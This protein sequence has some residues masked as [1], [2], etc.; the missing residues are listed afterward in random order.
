MLTDYLLAAALALAASALACRAMIAVGILDGPTSERKKENAPT[1]AS[2]GIAIGLG[3]AL[4]L[5]LLV[6]PPVRDWS[7]GLAPS[8]ALSALAVI[9]LSFAFLAV[10]AVDDVRAIESRVKFALFALA[11]LTGPVLG[12]RADVMPLGAGL[13]LHLPYIVAVLGSALWVFTLVN[14]VNFMDG[15][16]GLAMGSVGAGLFFLGLL[17]LVEEQPGTAALAFCGAAALA[18]FLFWNMPSGRLFAGDSGAL[19]AGALAAFTSLLYLAESGASPLLPTILFFPLLA[20]VLLTL[21]YRLGRGAR[22]LDGHRNHFYQVGRRAGMSHAAVSLRYWLLTALCGVIALA[23]A[24]L[25]RGDLSLLVRFGPFDAEARA[26][27][28]YAP[29]IAFLALILASLNVQARVRAFA[30][31]RGLE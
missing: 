9:G 1:P 18:G 12:L 29:T 26:I 11:S 2:G 20:D 7:A 14:A 23:A 22:L 21:A 17:A 27:A 3:F 13:A 30:R 28:S 6:F 10:G 4:G 25:A 19:F 8:T 15:A 24:L 31:R 16:N 5:A